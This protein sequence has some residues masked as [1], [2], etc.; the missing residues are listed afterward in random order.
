MIYNWSKQCNIKLDE[1]GFQISKF[2]IEI[3]AI[4]LG[5]YNKLNRGNSNYKQSKI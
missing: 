2:E 5:E 4:K 3:L 1:Y